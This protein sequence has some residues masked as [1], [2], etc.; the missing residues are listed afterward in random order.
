M[1]SNWMGDR[2]GRTRAVGIRKDSDLL[3]AY[4]HLGQ[5]F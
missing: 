5:H 1:V 2:L 3:P 4:R